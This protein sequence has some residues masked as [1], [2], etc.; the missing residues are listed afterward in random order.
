[1]FFGINQDRFII[2]YFKFKVALLR[3]LSRGKCRTTSFP[4]AQPNGTSR[5]WTRTVSI[6]FAINHGALNH[7]IPLP[8]KYK[9]WIDVIID[10]KICHV[11][12]STDAV[13]SLYNALNG[14]VLSQPNGAS[15]FWTTNVSITF[16]INHGALNTCNLTTLPTKYKPCNNWRKKSGL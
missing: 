7:S 16:G 12:N 5:F 14:E 1:M 6:T 2:F 15:R 13:K 10:V 3:R 4:R 9:P 8:I 11:N